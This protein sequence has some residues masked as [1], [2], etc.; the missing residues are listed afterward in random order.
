MEMPGDLRIVDSEPRPLCGHRRL[1]FHLSFLA[2]AI[3]QILCFRC[4]DRVAGG[5]WRFSDRSPH[6]VEKSACRCVLLGRYEVDL[7]TP[8][9][10]FE[11]DFTKVTQHSVFNAPPQDA[12]THEKRLDHDRFPSHSI[13]QRSHQAVVA[14][15]VADIHRKASH[16]R[17]IREPRDFSLGSAHSCRIELIRP[18]R[19][20]RYARNLARDQWLDRNP[21][22]ECR[23][24]LFE[25]RGLAYHAG[26]QLLL[27]VAFI[28]LPVL[29]GYGQPIE[30]PNMI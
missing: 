9:I 17:I 29:L 22:I 6:A 11:R 13:E 3:N 26:T 5:N 15:S 28:A 7:H 16:V 21:Q 4:A 20:L 1:C 19:Q 25:R 12:A 2:G 30:R 23:N 8:D 18:K 10:A 27:A 14:E 24:E